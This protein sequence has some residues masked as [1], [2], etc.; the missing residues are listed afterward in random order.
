MI[1][2]GTIASIGSGLLTTID[3]HTHPAKWAGLLAL[4]GVGVGMASQLPY[5]ALQVVLEY[6]S[7]LR[8]VR[9]LHSEFRLIKS[10]VQ[11]ILLLEMVSVGFPVRGPFSAN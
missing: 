6:V 3:M 2:G 8:S 11:Q 5:T 4:T 9:K 1:A 10:K 7:P